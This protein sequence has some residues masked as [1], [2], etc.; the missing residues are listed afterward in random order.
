MFDTD[1]RMDCAHRS[2]QWWARPLACIFLAICGCSDVVVAQR[3]GEESEKAQSAR[4]TSLKLESVVLVQRHGV[5]SPTQGIATLKTWAEKDWPD[6]KVGPGELTDHGKE[7]VKL[8]ARTVGNEYRAQ[9]LLSGSC[10]DVKRRIVVW[11]DEK[12]RRT[13]ESGKLLAAELAPACRFDVPVSFRKDRDLI[14]NSIDSHCYLDPEQVKSA[15]KAVLGSQEVIDTLARE[16]LDF[17]QQ[18]MAPT[19]CTHGPGTCLDGKSEID[20]TS[21]HVELKGPLA[22]GSEAAEI[23][24]LQYAQGMSVNEVAWGHGAGVKQIERFMAAHERADQLTRNL[25]YIA[26]RRGS[27]MARLILDTLKGSGHSGEPSVPQNVEVLALAGHDT[28]LSNMAGIFGLD[29]R[30]DGQPDSTAPATALAFELWRD[31]K[32]NVRY[33]KPK[34]FYLAL[35]Q[36]RD[37]KPEKA[38][39]STLAFKHCSNDGPDGLCPLRDLSQKIDQA[40]PLSCR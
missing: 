38:R 14:F 5:R 15:V 3:A 13:R 39:N 40:T 6:W 17:I 16:A 33:V 24:L 18:A 21:D 37:L 26:L 12:D 27:R 20:A 1:A 29:L 7:V 11:A 9:G 4:V 23:F 35:S 2:A 22:I 36:M 8:V 25:D 32:T 10:L 28:N 19:A 31:A 34:V 30:V